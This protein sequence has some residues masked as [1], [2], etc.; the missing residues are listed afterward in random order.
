MANLAFQDYQVP[1][2]F[3]AHR[4]RLVSRVHRDHRDL[5]VTRALTGKMDSQGRMAG[6]VNRELAAVRETREIQAPPALRAT[7]LKACV[8]LLVR[9]APLV[10]PVCRVHQEYRA[11]KDQE[12][13]EAL[14]A[15]PEQK[16]RMDREER[17][18]S[19]VARVNQVKKASQAKR[20]TSVHRARL[21][22]QEMMV[23]KW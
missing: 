20:A 8:D 21:G 5:K 3:Q 12:D 2:E 1:Q 14:R 7:C 18:A 4:D 22:R 19:R 9:S 11:P 15:R 23:M 17:E 6:T 10:P 16:E 13:H